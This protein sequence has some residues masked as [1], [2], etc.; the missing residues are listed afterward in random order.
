MQDSHTADP[1]G[2]THR[3]V[4]P[5]MLR[6]I[7]ITRIARMLRNTELDMALGMALDIATGVRI[8]RD[9]GVGVETCTYP[10]AYRNSSVE[11]RSLT[12]C[13]YSRWSTISQL[14]EFRRENM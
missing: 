13:G 1:L 9:N 7:H 8:A 12:N 3:R 6:D 4:A 5:H 2:L 10:A 14:L 11:A